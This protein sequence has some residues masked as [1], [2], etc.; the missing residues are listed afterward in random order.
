MHNYKFDSKGVT[1]IK[2]LKEKSHRLLVPEK[3][4]L[5]RFCHILAL[6]QSRMCN[7]SV[8]LNQL[9]SLYPMDLN[10]TSELSAL[11]V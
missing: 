9:F 5:E 11:S 4:I 2:S 6:Q 3:T 7:Q 10:V 8:P 1:H